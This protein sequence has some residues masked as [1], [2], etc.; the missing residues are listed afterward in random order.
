MLHLLPR[1]SLPLGVGRLLLEL[2]FVRKGSRVNPIIKRVLL[3]IT[4]Y[5][6]LVITINVPCKA[7]IVHEQSP[8]PGK[9]LLRSSSA[10]SATYTLPAIDLQAIAR[11]D[12][13]TDRDKSIPMRFAIPFK[14]QLNPSN[15]GYW[16]PTL[17]RGRIWSLS[18]KSNGAKSLNIIFSTFK[19]LDGEQ[20]YL[21]SENKVKYYGPFTARNNKPWGSLAT[22]PVEGQRLTVEYY[23]PPGRS[24]T[25]ALELGQI[26]HGYRG[27]GERKNEKGFDD[28][29]SCN[30][31]VVCQEWK[32]WEC[33]F[34][35]VAKVF[36]GGT[37]ICSGSLVNNH[38][39]DGRPLFL[40]A[41]HCLDGEEEDWVFLF[42]W[43]SSSCGTNVE[44]EQKHTISGSEI[45][46][47]NGGSDFA[48][49]ELSEKP[50]V[51][52]E[53]FYTGWDAR[54]I[55]PQ[56]T[57]TIG[58]PAG[59]Q[60]KIALDEHPAGHGSW[61]D[62]R[63]WSVIW[64]DGTTQSGSS[65]C[66]LWD[67]NFRL[68]GQ[69]YGGDAACD[70]MSDSDEYGRL[71]LSWGLGIKKYLDP[72]NTG[73]KVLDGLGTGKCAQTHAKAAFSVSSYKTCDGFITFTDASRNAAGWNW[74]FGDGQS[75]TAQ[76][77]EHKYS[78][79]GTYEVK[80]DV[81]GTTGDNDSFT[82]TIFVSPTAALSFTSC[83]DKKDIV[84]RAQ[85][86]QTLTID[87]Y[88]NQNDQTP[89]STGDSLVFSSLTPTETYYANAYEEHPIHKVGPGDNTFG[90]GKYFEQNTDYGLYLNI[91]RPI[92][93]KSIKF[94][95]SRS[96]ERTIDLKNLEQNTRELREVSIPNGE[97]KV[98][99]DWHIEPGK[100]F[101]KIKAG[102]DV[103]LYRNTDGAKYPY[104]VPG[105]F[106]IERSSAPG[107]ESDYFYFFYE[108]EIQEQVCETGMKQVQAV[109]TG[110]CGDTDDSVE[111]DTDQSVPGGCSAA[112]EAGNDDRLFTLLAVVMVGLRLRRRRRGFE[113]PS[114]ERGGA[115][116]LRAQ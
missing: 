79:A 68:I 85:N 48:L 4:I 32:D 23:I 93:V 104:S 62:A 95:S 105:L 78:N 2:M 116:T 18:I 63:T 28:S 94:F 5:V 40:T 39:Q 8:P 77:P 102:S 64:D 52:Y 24:T 12:A 19:L 80:L 9:A 35:S 76:N 42:N 61:N 81:T 69:L 47:Q 60:M 111:S 44:T 20:V 106:S 112:R 25:G 27:F 43:K 57:V 88:E 1:Q 91:E 55:T 54:G 49:L 115:A 41:E 110:A 66:G 109:N 50:P 75:S 31:N 96:G 70:A 11:E 108:W 83:E 114:A 113:S 29:D 14:V 59:D 100:Y 6:L 36:K 51:S 33:H 7:Q 74:S 26:A 73:N 58:H 89:V 53:L 72:D 13:V 38:R 67:E 107:M 71:D 10:A 82:D 3:V 22:L 103:G 17:G 56:R 45:L 87:W 98:Q 21:R 84:V 30:N 99:M 46:T 37:R 97:Q 90:D 92:V 16:Q 86:A 15:S 34:G 101:V 65:G